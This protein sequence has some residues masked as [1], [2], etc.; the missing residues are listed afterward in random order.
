MYSIFKVLSS[1]NSYFMC[2]VFQFVKIIIIVFLVLSVNVL[3]LARYRLG[4]LRPSYLGY[5]CAGF[6]I[7]YC[8][9]CAWFFSLFLS[10]SQGIQCR[11]IMLE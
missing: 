5:V 10:C 3:D 7:R 1:V 11:N 9:S 6:S 4:S 2:T 8:L